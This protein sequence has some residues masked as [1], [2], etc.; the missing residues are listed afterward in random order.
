MSEKDGRIN[1][2]SPSTSHS[3]KEN[4]MDSEDYSRDTYLMAA[5]EEDEFNSEK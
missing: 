3:Y 2:M 1:A 4:D 5:D